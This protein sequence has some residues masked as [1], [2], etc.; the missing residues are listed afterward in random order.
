MMVVKH[1]NKISRETILGD[2]ENF[3]EEGPE[4]LA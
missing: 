1:L 2:M 3:N 4:E